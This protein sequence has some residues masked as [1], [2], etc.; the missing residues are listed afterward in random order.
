MKNMPVSEGIV[1]LDRQQSKGKGTIKSVFGEFTSPLY[2]LAA[3]L[4]RSA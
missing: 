1:W 2:Y 4:S 3:V